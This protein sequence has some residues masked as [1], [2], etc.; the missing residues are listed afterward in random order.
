MDEFD[1]FGSDPV[2]QDA[3][4][5]DEGDLLSLAQQVFRGKGYC[6]TMRANARAVLLKMKRND[7]EALGF[8]HLSHTNGS[9]V[10]QGMQFWRWVVL[11][12]DL[13]PASQQ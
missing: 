13:S 1:I 11:F 3:V 10:E 6:D 8:Q 2:D 5:L 12:F 4:L 7:E 9:R